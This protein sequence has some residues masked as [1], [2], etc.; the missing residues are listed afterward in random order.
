MRYVY[1]A[2]NYNNMI[3]SKE[4]KPINFI[5]YRTETT[6]NELVNLLPVGQELFK[7]AV[8]IKIY[9]TGPVHWHY[10]GITADLTKSFIVEVSVPVA[11]IPK[12]YDGSFHFKR[13]EPFKCVSLIHE[14]A[15]TDIPQ[16]YGMLMQYLGEHQLTPV[17]VNR[18]V[19]VNADFNYPDAN[20]TEIQ[21]GIA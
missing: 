9:I 7:E 2:K 3:Q 13:T 16:S 5:Y 6:V 14:G 19:Y 17:G 8:R 1:L 18:E 11:E 4:V 12:E 20:T 21:F 15:W 10:I